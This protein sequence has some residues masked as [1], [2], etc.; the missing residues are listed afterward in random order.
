VAYRG[1]KLA[2][3]HVTGTWLVAVNSQYQI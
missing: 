1:I 2:D 3:G